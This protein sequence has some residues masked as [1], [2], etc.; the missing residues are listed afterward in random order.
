MAPRK[1]GKLAR[2]FGIVI[3]I[4]VGL[5]TLLDFA[6]LGLRLTTERWRWLPT[7]WS[8]LIRE[9][10]RDAW[11]ELPI[12]IGSVVTGLVALFLCRR[13]YR[14]AGSDDAELA[15]SFRGSIAIVSVLTVLSGFMTCAGLIRAGHAIDRQKEKYTLA[16][17]RT[18]GTA[19]ENYASAHHGHV[20]QVRDIHALAALLEPDYIRRFPLTDNWG[21]PF[22]YQ[23][24]DC[25]DNACRSYFIGSGGKDGRFERWP[26]SAYGADLLGKSMS[27]DEDLVLSNGAFI[28][29]RVAPWLM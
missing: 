20:P 21:R 8:S 15:D 9:N 2:R 6:G 19:T 27:F 28:K 23:A 3:S 17:I 24:G 13:I 11:P 16:T 12:L 22:A 10:A 4:L 1:A 26:L 14:L 25:T 29:L 5:L 7:G 18:I